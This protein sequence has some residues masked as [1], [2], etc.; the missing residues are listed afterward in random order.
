MKRLKTFYA[1]AA[2]IFLLLPAWAHAGSISEQDVKDLMARADRA[3]ATKN[4]D[5]LAGLLSNSARINLAISQNGSVQKM[6]LD[7]PGYMNLVKRAWSAIEDYRYER[8]N[9]KISINGNTATVTNDAHESMKVQGQRLS[10]DSKETTV[11]V[12]EQG[13]LMVSRV[14][15]S[16]M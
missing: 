15:A 9:V 12:V 13:K 11:L 4:A 2:A 1:A 7:K 6:N 10:S 5:E 3:I 14:D 16:S 8:S